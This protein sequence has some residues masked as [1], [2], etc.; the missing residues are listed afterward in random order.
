MR[1]LSWFVMPAVCVLLLRGFVCAE[2]AK[3][4]APEV[5]VTVFERLD[6]NK[7]KK[8]SVEEFQA[9]QA[10]AQI[11][12]ALRDFDLFDRDADDFLSLEEF[13]SLPTGVSANQRGPLPDPV[14]AVVEQFVGILDQRLEDWD[15]SPERTV[16]VNQFVSVFSETLNEPLTPQMLREAD[17]DLDR[18]VTRAEAKRFVEIQAGVRRSDGKLIREANGKV[19]GQIQFLNA[20]IN[21]D[22]SVSLP[23]FLE[24]G[25]A[26]EK[27]AEIFKTNDV[28]MDGLLTWEE[29]IRFRIHDPIWEF[30]RLDVNLDGHGGD[31]RLDQ[32]VGEGRVPR[33]RHRQERQAVAG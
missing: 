6:R 2:D 29:W 33:V 22:D 16:P 7:D 8:L 11:G 24:R 20:D 9:A 17:P 23:E 12:V 19:F 28:D 1:R 30:R 26:G 25:Y 5:V 15:K 32:G 13:W 27:A 21:R 18:Q 4:T 10:A 31:A 14:A 3:P